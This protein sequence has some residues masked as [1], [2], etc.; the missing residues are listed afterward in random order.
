MRILV[1]NGLGVGSRVP[2]RLPAHEAGEGHGEVVTFQGP[3][4]VQSTKIWGIYGFYIRN[5]NNGF[6]NILCIWV[7]GPLGDW[8]GLDFA[9]EVA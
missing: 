3:L 1:V 6:G 5:R 4:T 2:L 8:F 7:L 9:E